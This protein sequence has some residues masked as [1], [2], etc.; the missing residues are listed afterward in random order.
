[1]TSS[2]GIDD[3]EDEL[4]ELDKPLKIKPAIVQTPILKA[5]VNE[6]IPVVSETK[7]GFTSIASPININTKVNHFI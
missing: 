6:N 3:I 1:M 2:L 7:D 4:N 5:D